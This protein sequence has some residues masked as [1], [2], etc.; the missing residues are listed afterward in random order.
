M[1][2]SMAARHSPEELRMFLLDFKEGVEFQQF[3]A[4][5]DEGKALPH[6]EVVSVESDAEFGVA[7]LNHFLVELERRSQLYKQVNAANIRDY[8]KITGEVL[9]RWVLFVDE[10][11]GMF[12]EPT[13]QEATLRLEDLVRRGHSFGLHVVLASQTLS[14]IRFESNK[15]KAIFEN[16]P[17]RVVLQLGREESV[18]FLG[19]GNDEAAGLRYRDQAILNTQ[20]GAVDANTH[21][22]VAYADQEY[23]DLQ[24]SLWDASAGLEG[25]TSKSPTLYKGDQYAT[26]GDL[27]RRNPPPKGEHGELPIW[28]GQESTVE[29]AAASGVLAPA[30]GNNVLVLGNQDPLS[31][32]AT[33]QTLT[34]SAV[35]AATERIQVLLLDTPA[36]RVRSRIDTERWV[37]ALQKLGAQVTRFGLGE[38]QDFLDAVNEAADGERRPIAVI[39][40]G[41]NSAFKEVADLDWADSI[42]NLPRRNVNVIGQWAS[43]LDVAGDSYSLLQD[44]E[45][46]LFV[47]ASKQDIEAATQRSSMDVPEPK[48]TRT[49]V[50]SAASP[51]KQLSRITGL[52]PLDESDYRAWEALA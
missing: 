31:A 27:L 14:G 34:L 9:P 51:T 21:F 33:T 29:G 42:R 7:A 35:A 37:Q 8:R 11:Q 23:V 26:S 28:F 25:S 2:Y 24:N 12:T 16:M 39:I 38:E 4:T 36:R 30:G 20:S 40:G 50:F 41:E 18:N 1:V 46:A 48:K 52:R 10:F 13:Y 45:T 32:I 43:H 22:V 47:G 49:V 15:D 17:A 5:Q 3:A 44:H 19:S 6:A